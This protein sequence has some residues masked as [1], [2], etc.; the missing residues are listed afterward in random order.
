MPDAVASLP[1]GP[2]APRLWQLCR[3]QLDPLAYVEACAARYGSVFTL[4]MHVVGTFVAVVDPADVQT[5][6]ADAPDRFPGEQDSSPLTPLAG[7]TAMM[8]ATGATHRA[9]R[10]VLLPAFHGELSERWSARVA[11]LTARELR[12]VPFGRPT[13]MLLAM[14]RLVL[15]ALCELLFGADDDARRA[16]RLREEVGRRYDARLLLMILFPTL[17]SRGGRL[18]PGLALKRRRDAANRL[19]LEQISRRRAAM[20]GKAR[21]GH[22]DAERDDALSLLVSARDEHGRPLSDA[23]IRDQLITLVMVGHETTATALAWMLERLSRTP[24]AL[25]RAT[26]AAHAADA[27]D[28][29][30]IA[31]LDAVVRESL[32]ARPSL[33][34]A[35]RTTAGEIRL[36]GHRIP[37]G[38]HV[39]AMLAAMHR[40]E[41]V[42][43]EPDAFMPERFLDGSAP[44]RAFAPFGGGPRRCLASAFSLLLMRVV[45]QTT[46]RCAAL[47]PAPGREEVARLSRI[48]LVPSRGARVV[49]HPPHSA[50]SS[51]ISAGRVVSQ[52]G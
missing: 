37:P 13:P 40:R 11:A 7:E 34:D 21:A 6:L 29:G 1:P 35:P 20:A 25:A 10:K 30:E 4:R 48:A 42:W 43:K 14:R 51:S 31:Y 2:R 17:W 50:R 18:N 36:G 41:D 22:A 3:Y 8:F 46:L 23:H 44:A 32:R 38:T 39:S 12:R 5:V 16:A 9:Q 24:A 28:A 47:A 49:L 26:A 33:M 45:L 52:L 19:L 15:E 27:G